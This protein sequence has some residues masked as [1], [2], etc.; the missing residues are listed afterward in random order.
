ML[1]LVTRISF[2]DREKKPRH[3]WGV[4]RYLSWSTGA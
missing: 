2:L 3:R 4:Y 1:S